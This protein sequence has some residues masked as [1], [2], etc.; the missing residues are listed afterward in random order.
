MTNETPSGALADTL[1]E[2]SLHLCKVM[3]LLQEASPEEWREAEFRLET[4]RHL[5]SQLPTKPRAR[6]RVGFVTQKR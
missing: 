3:F 2:L 5:F 6:R 1:H 4:V